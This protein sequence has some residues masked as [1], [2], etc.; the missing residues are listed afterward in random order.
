[1]IIVLGSVIVK[2][3]GIDE[4]LEI[5]QQ[6]VNRSRCEPGCIAHDVHLDPED[7]QRLVFV[8]KWSDQA[9]LSQHFKKATSLEF[10]EKIRELVTKA[11][12]MA[13]Y[14]ATQLQ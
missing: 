4:A 8:E 12:E 3:G 9:S 14:D 2:Q 11:P 10:V 6:H 1:M 13:V 7:P 5:S